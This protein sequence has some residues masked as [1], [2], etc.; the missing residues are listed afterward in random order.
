MAK[1]LI[2]MVI[3][4]QGVNN[5]INIILWKLRSF[6][7]KLGMESDLLLVLYCICVCVCVCDAIVAMEV[8]ANPW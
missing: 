5:F 1:N 3:F 4:V 8:I 6:L 7:E 2:E